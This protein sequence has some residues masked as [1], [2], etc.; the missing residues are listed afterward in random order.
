MIRKCFAL[1]AA[2]S[3]HPLSAPVVASPAAGGEPGLTALER[4]V[5]EWI[6]AH[7][8]EAIALLAE[9]VEISS[10]TEDLE[11]VRRV[12]AVFARELAAIGF[13]NRWVDLPPELRRAGHLFSE[14]RGERGKRLLLIGHLDTVLPS[15]GFRREGEIGHGSG[16][17]DMKGGNV[18]LLWALKALHAAGALDGHQVTVALIGDEEAAGRPLEVARAPLV[19]AAEESDVALAF[20]GAVPGVAVVGRRGIGSWRLEVTALTGHSSLIFTEELG[21]GA[22]LEAARILDG[23]R[24]QLVGQPF[25]TFNPSVAVGGSQVEYDAAESRGTAHGKN[26]VIPDRVVVTGDLRFISREQLAEV[27]GSMRRIAGAGNLPLTRATLEFF[28]GYPPMAPTAGNYAALSL[29]D[30]VSRDLGHGPVEPHDPGQ[31]GAA[32]VSFVA[33]VVEA[34][35]DGLGA[36]GDREHAP[37]ELVR[38]DQLPMLMQRAALL[39]HRLLTLPREQ[40]LAAAPRFPES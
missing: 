26:N 20:E 39:V 27:Q 36:I 16:A 10:P 34:A 18:V 21:Y 19:A 35:L 29:L 23:F 8:E 1:A 12:G 22:I 15:T 2:L 11:G 38:L 17:S 5:V 13:E 32:D 7:Q 40:P 6:D 31:R 14:R 24:R 30:E 9:T 28:E 33:H 3:L 25:L 37:D 4:R